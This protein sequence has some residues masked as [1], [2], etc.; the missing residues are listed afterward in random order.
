MPR[1]DLV[2]LTAVYGVTSQL[3]TDYTSE[4]TSEVSICTTTS[5]PLHLLPS[6]DRMFSLDTPQKAYARGSVS[7]YSLTPITLLH[8]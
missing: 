6:G 8:Y 5:I 1:M 2:S 3:T 4:D 7:R